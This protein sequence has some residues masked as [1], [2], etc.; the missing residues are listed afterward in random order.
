MIRTVEEI[1][2]N[3]IFSKKKKKRGHIKRI[4]RKKK[5]VY[6]LDESICYLSEE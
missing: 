6:N 5:W 4:T 2:I 3:I 1:Y